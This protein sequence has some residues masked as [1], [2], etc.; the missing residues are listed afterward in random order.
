M[1]LTQNLL[2]L[3]FPPVCG[4]C[5]NIDKNFLCDKCL[6]KYDELKISNIDDYSNVPVYFR[7]HYYTF[8]YENEIR[9]FIIKYKFD[10][11][12]YLYKTFSKFILQD[13]VFVENFI[14]KYDVILSVPI[15]KKRM[16]VR[17]Y[18]QSRL[19]AEDI[20][21]SLREGLL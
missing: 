6:K 11:K 5:N 20:A 15:H 17:G 10:E 7:E 2:N 13:K 19:I 21:G 14:Y 8:K 3:I 4:F 18:N 1:N 16:K 9:D 12:S